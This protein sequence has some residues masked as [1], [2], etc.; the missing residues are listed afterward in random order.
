MVVSPNLME[1]YQDD[2]ARIKVALADHPKGMS[3]TDIAKKVG[4]HRNSVAKYMDIL[5]IQG[6]VDEYKVGTSKLYFLTSRLPARAVQKVCTRPLLIIDKNAVITDTNKSFTDLVGIPR[7]R[8]LGLAFDSVPVK[9]IEAGNGIQ[10]IR[11]ALRGTEQHVVGRVTHSAGHQHAATLLLEPV[12]FENGKPGA[13]LIIEEHE[14]HVPGTETATAFSDIL[15]LLDE[16]MEYVI[17]HTP[18]GIIRFVNGTYCRA[19]GKT[20]EELMNQPFK[21]LVSAE[22]ANRIQKFRVSLTPE[23]PVGTIE[24]RAV[25]A[26]GEIRWQ[27]WTDR[28]LFDEK[29]VLIGYQSCGMDITELMILKHDLLKSQELLDD[30]IQKRTVELREINRQLYAEISDRDKTAQHYLLMQF[31]MENAFDM[32]FWVNKNGRV[33]YANKRACELLKYPMH[34]LQNIPFSAILPN[35]GSDLWKEQL[36]RTKNNQSIRGSNV[37][38]ISKTR[39]EIPVDIVVRQLIYH[40]DE[41]VCCFTGLSPE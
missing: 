6:A 38:M 11:A 28:A 2:I 17:R 29:G 26:D 40:G 31:I 25:M 35:Y 4:I 21:P 5:H 32:V 9:I 34:E 8:I 10:V 20:K 15:N 19:A 18:D 39:E 14:F 16:E 22:D 41:I 27:R 13:A 1:R 23:N 3:I 30:A 24:F 33:Q 36:N 12:V 7:D 37:V